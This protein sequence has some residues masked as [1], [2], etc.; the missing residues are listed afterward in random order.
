MPSSPKLALLLLLLLPLLA[1]SSEKPLTH[2]IYHS[3]SSAEE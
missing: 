2:P 1:A 3:E